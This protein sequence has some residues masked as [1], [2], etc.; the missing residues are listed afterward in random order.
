LCCFFFFFPSLSPPS[1]FF[2]SRHY[3]HCDGEVVNMTQFS[4]A[5]LF[6]FFP[7]FSHVSFFILRVFWRPATGTSSN[8]RGLS[9][10][11]LSPFS[12]FFQ[13]FFF[14][15]IRARD[16]T[17]SMLAGSV[18]AGGLP[19][20]F[21][22]FPPRVSLLFRV[23]LFRLLREHEHALKAPPSPP[24]SPSFFL[25]CLFSQFFSLVGTT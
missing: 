21:F 24:F 13:L 12:P 10:L 14:F 16:V 23:F 9:P 11:F 6:S 4:L 3:R 17:R 2:S 5:L 20:F 25:P 8:A 22:F 18:P 7:P 19:R 1:F 15:L